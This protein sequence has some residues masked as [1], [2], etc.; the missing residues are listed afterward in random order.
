MI[1]INI[2]Q[3]VDLST[4]KKIALVDEVEYNNLKAENFNL[5]QKILELSSNERILQ[6]TIKGNEMTINELR[7]ENNELKQRICVLEKIING[8]LEKNEFSKFKKAIQDL[9]SEYKLETKV[10][11]PTTL[12]DLREDRVDECHYLN[13]RWTND[14]KDYRIYELGKRIQ[15]MSN[16]VMLRFNNI[17]PG[18]IN[19]ILPYT[20]I[21]I[22]TMISQKIKDKTNNWWDN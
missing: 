10:N 7:K 4:N 16:N 11:D 22:N 12:E 5:K 20:Q 15:Q 8:L 13:K 17:Y 18:L 1:P 19:D 2:T 3:Y 6:E 9:N 21:Q 14:E